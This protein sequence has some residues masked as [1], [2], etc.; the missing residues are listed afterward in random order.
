M[1]IRFKKYSKIVDM[2]HVLVCRLVYF[3][4][5]SCRINLALSR[6]IKQKNARTLNERTSFKDQSQLNRGPTMDAT[7]D[8]EPTIP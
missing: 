7:R 2:K 6:R 5:L 4:E 1:K 8:E 3:S